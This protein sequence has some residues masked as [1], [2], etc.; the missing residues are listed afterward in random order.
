MQ[1]PSVVVRIGDPRLNKLV[2]EV[3]D[4]GECIV[5]PTDT[6]YGIASQPD[7]PVAVSRLQQIKGRSDA[8]PPPVL[9]ADTDDAWS[10]V[11]DVPQAARRLGEAYWPGALTLILPTDK[12]LSLAEQVGT[13]GV[14]V[15]DLDEIR[16]LLRGTGPLAV[17]S[18]N[19][20]NLAPATSVDEAVEQLGDEVGLYIDGG[21]TPGPSPS[22]VVDCTTDPVTIVRLGLL[23]EEQILTV[24]GAADA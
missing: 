7:N 20:H 3:L 22:T 17:S 12:A 11:T 21:P 8:F 6:V 10:L 13:I 15:P 18:A 2:E 16:A 4:R 14:R 1:N 5:F 9:A 23:T 24:A 19:K